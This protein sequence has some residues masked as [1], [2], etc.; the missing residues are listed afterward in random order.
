MP[1]NTKLTYMYRDASNNKSMRQVVFSGRLAADHKQSLIASMIPGENDEVAN[2]IPGL[3]GLPDLQDKFYDQQITLINAMMEHASKDPVK[4]SDVDHKILG[5]FQALAD[6]MAA[7]KPIWWP[8]DT[9]GHEILEI[10]DTE[11]ETTDARSIQA[12]AAVVAVVDW[13][14]DYLPPFHAEMLENY[15]EYLKNEEFDPPA[16]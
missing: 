13:D 12:F 9:T 11:R 14:Q 16:P 3:V 5:D 10:A 6:D 1:E 15:I 2:F 4:R 7:V 8:D